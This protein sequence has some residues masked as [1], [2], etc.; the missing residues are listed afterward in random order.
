MV[1]CTRKNDL[2]ARKKTIET[3]QATKSQTK[4]ASLLRI[5]FDQ[6][7]R[8]MQR[9]VKRGLDRRDNT[10][11]YQYLS[12]DEKAV[13]RGHEYVSILSDEG[14]GLVLGVVEGRT[15]ESVDILCQESL[16]KSQ[17]EQVKTLCTDM[18]DAYIYGANRYFPNALH[19]HDNFHL[20]GYL[21]KAVDKVR[22]REVK[23]QEELKQTKYLFLKDQMNLT[24]KQRIAFDAIKD[25]NYETSKAW[26]VK[27]NFRDIQFRQTIEEAFIIYYRWKGD[28]KHAQI[29]EINEVVDMFARHEIGIINA[30]H[31]GANNARAE[32]LN[33][34]IQEVKTIGRGYRKTE[35]FIT[36]IMFFHA[37]LNLFPQKSQ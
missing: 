26:R 8:I 23:Y 36:A 5:S 19:C 3:L 35:N 13:H 20:V 18:W 7:H 37:G 1:R 4:T 17:R 9:A 25:C 27:E 34:A 29:K 22:R 31:T 12:I 15:M 30:I 33:G 21:N 24:E 10:E 14:S 28:A 16:T 6:V 32:R 11:L 2:D